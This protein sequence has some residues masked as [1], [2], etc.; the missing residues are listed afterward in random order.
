MRIYPF[1]FLIFEI[2]VDYA[3]LALE[4]Y[5]VLLAVWTSRSLLRA[6]KSLLKTVDSLKD[7]PI[8]SF[9]QV[10]L[11]FIWFVAVLNIISIITG[12]EIA[13]FLTAMGALSAVILLIFKDTIL[14]FVASIQLSTNDLIRIGDWITMEAIW[15]RWRCSRNQFE[16]SKNSKF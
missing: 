16:F 11:N 1:G 10:I 3:F 2:I 15:S 14:G 12:K 8:E 7:K 13:T 4:I 6:F 9:V 5:H